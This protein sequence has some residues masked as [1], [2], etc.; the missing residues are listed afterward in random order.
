MSERQARYAQPARCLKT[1]DRFRLQIAQRL[2]ISRVTVRKYLSADMF[3]EHRSHT[4]APRLLQPY[5]VHLERRWKEGC[6][7]ALEL[8]REIRAQG[9]HGSSRQMHRWGSPR[10]ETVAKNTPHIR[11]GRP[12]PPPGKK[13]SRFP[14]PRA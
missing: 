6:R 2:G 11:R 1:V 4:T 3:P 5:D 14:V 13:R 10:R 9:Y 7:N 8:W 12:S